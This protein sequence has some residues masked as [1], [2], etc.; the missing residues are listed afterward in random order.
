[1]KPRHH[2]S[3]TAKPLEPTDQEPNIE[4]PVRTPHEQE[5]ASDEP[6]PNPLIT[7]PTPDIC[8]P[9]N[10]VYEPE[11]AP[12]DF[13]RG[14]WLNPDNSIWVREANRGVKI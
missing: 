11:Y 1:M 8:N 5:D 2:L 6:R 12:K 3:C 14:P 13:Q 7:T 9:D 10:G 4:A